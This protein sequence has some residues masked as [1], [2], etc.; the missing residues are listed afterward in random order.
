MYNDLKTH[1][2]NQYRLSAN[3]VFA[4]FLYYLERGGKD[5][6]EF[7]DANLDLVETV[8]GGPDE[9]AA[10][11]AA[12]K[13]DKE[14]AENKEYFFGVAA[15]MLSRVRTLIQQKFD[16]SVR[17]CEQIGIEVGDFDAE[18]LLP[19]VRRSDE[20]GDANSDADPN[21]GITGSDPDRVDEIPSA[22]G[23]SKSEISDD[24]KPVETVS[25]EQSIPTDRPTDES[26]EATDINDAEAEPEKDAVEKVLDGDAMT[27]DDLKALIG[28]L[29]AD[30]ASKSEIWQAVTD[31]AGPLGWGAKRVWAYVDEIAP[32][33]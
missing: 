18:T 17:Y 15:K 32:K 31:V 19:G 12:I 6:D 10:I 9:V 25:E 3:K 30:G 14:A 23:A 33:Q 20:G 4:D 26:Q 1:W 11:I 24:E 21:V 13:T 5:A 22:D 28:T 2:A 8:A 7:I 29:V 27:E 16:A